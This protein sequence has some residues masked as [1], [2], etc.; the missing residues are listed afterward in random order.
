MEL[1]WLKRSEVSDKKWDDCINH[2]ANGHVFAYTW[3]LDIVCDDWQAVVADDY[4]AVLPLPI[5]RQTFKG[6]YTPHWTPY[7]GIVNRRPICRSDAFNMLKAIPSFNIDLIMGTHNKLPGIK[8][9]KC[10]SR[11]FAVLDLIT[12]MSRIE[13]LIS[14]EINP[15]IDVYKKKKI[16][17]GLRSFFP[18]P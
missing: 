2:S 1:K 7:L 8:A 17:K 3:Y 13:K 18:H 12:E 5:K 9:L 14:P 6:V 4:E 15:V 16:N 10:E 11:R